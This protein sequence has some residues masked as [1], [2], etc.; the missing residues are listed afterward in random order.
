MPPASAARSSCVRIFSDYSAAL[1]LADL[2]IE[3]ISLY[4]RPEAGT[5]KPRL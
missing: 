3:E 4:I 5:A 1:I 2:R